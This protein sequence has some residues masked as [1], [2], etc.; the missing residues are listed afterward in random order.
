MKIIGKRARLFVAAAALSGALFAT[1]ASSPAGASVKPADTG[2][3]ISES[4]SPYG[5]ILVAGSG[6]F[7]GFSLYFISSDSGGR[8]GCTT[9]VV[10]VLGVHELSCIDEWPPLL[11]S[12]TPV[13]GT[14]VDQSLL[15]S[16]YRPS[17]GASQ[18]TYKGHPLY[19]FDEAPGQYTGEAFN[20]PSLPPWHG[21]WYLISPTGAPVVPVAKIKTETIDGSDT[22]LGATMHTLL[23][24]VTFTVYTFSADT[25][26]HT[27]CR[28]AC[29]VAWMPVLSSGPAKVHRGL[30]ARD[31]GTITLPNGTEQVTFDGQPLYLFSNEAV[32]LGSSGPVSE[33]NGN[34]ITAFGGTF[35]AVGAGG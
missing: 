22:V 1:G 11:T 7:A 20:E 30:E 19:L 13:A 17:L 33:G 14:G 24:S 10:I 29:A 4:S 2:T 27:N 34:G 3:T 26:E 12:G 5:N 18:V 8:Y 31:F 21:D 6:P 9:H 35:A 32:T 16:V 28:G 25:Y 15:G 23:G